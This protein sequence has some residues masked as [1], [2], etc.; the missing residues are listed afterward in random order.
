MRLVRGGASAK[1][2]KRFQL[3]GYRPFRMVWFVAMVV[4]LSV[5]PSLVSASVSRAAH[6]V[7]IG[8]L[9]PLTG[10]SAADGQEMVRGARLA[11]D[12]INAMGGIRGYRFAIVVGDTEDQK[13]DA[14]ASAVRRISDDR[15]VGAM[16]T[17]YADGTN[18]EIKLM[19]RLQMPYLISANSAQTRDIIAKDP[20]KYPTV[21]SLTPSYDAYGTALPPL[22]E[23]WAK[24]G[25]LKLHNHKAYIVTSDN[26]YSN[27]IAKG[28]AQTL[29]SMK[30]TLTGYD[31]V[32]F[33]TVSDWGS[34]ISKIRSDPPDLVI[35][36]DYQPGNDAT[37]MK[38]FLQNPTN[39]L[40]F[41]QYGPSVPE[42]VTLTKDQSTGVL[43]NLLGGPIDSPKLPRSAR[44]KRKFKAKYGVESGTYG[45]ALYEQIY[46]YAD[47]LKKV[48]NPMDKLAIG[49]ALGQTD[50]IVAEGRLKFDP[51]THLALQGDDYIPL[52]FF[53]LWHGQRILLTPKKWAT[54]T[55]HLPP[56]MKM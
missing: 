14:V 52:Q 47:A 48:G 41:I 40:V 34:T 53:Q 38:Q 20:S 2:T 43:Y 49:R 32:P 24:Q 44:I 8:V 29:K 18:F 17:G 4:L 42:F 3:G 54:G 31:T 10:G 12:E 45:V 11:V 33:G 25:F 6:V 51:K 16:M 22:V 36:T 56:W 1:I 5:V 35:N 46:L 13:P 39:S 27:T 28:L 26:P 21:W 55:F 50:K 19:S 23:S 7:K 37:F 9:A 30:W 15:A